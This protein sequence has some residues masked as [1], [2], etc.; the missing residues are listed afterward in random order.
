MG[1]QPVCGRG[2]GCDLMMFGDSPYVQYY[3]SVAQ[4]LL[5]HSYIYTQPK[6]PFVER[7]S[8]SICMDVGDLQAVHV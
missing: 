3:P 7:E 8:S 6:P 2:R 5:H 1:Q 4:S